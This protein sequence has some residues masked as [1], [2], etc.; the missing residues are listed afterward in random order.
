MTT[1]TPF[2]QLQAFLKEIFQ[3]DDHDLDFGIYRIIRLKRSFIE[4]FIDGHGQ[5]S[6]RAVVQE[7]LSQVRHDAGETARNWLSAFCAQFGERG[8]DLWRPLSDNPLDTRAR[9]KFQHFLDSPIIDEKDRDKALEHLE[10]LDESGKMTQADL[11]SRVYNHLLNFFELYYNNGDFGYNTRAS[12]AFKVPYEADYDG[13]DTMFHWKHKGSYYIKTGNGF[14]RIRSRINGAWLEF[15]I[16][17]RE[18]GLAS[19]SRNNVR[20]TQEKHYRL[21]QVR[22]VQDKDSEGNT[23]TVHQVLFSLAPKSTS[24]VKLYPA[25]WK[26]VFGSG[27]D[28]TPYLHKKPDKD[29]PFPGRPIFN[30]LSDSYD[31]VQSGGI[32]GVTQLRLK[33]ETY[34]TELAKRDEFKELGKNAQARAEA[35]GRDKTARALIEMDRR[36]NAFYAGNDA[37]FFIHKDLK[38]FLS[39]EKERYIKN[40]IFSDLNGLLNPDQDFAA[41]QVGRTFNQVADRIIAFLDAIENFQKKLFELKKKV[42]DTHYLISVGRIP[43][44]FYPRLFKCREQL[45][46][47]KDI[48][49]VD[50]RKPEDLTSHPTLVVDTGLY[51]QFDPD[52]QD[53]L[54][55]HPAFDHL[56]EQTDGLLI[57]SENWQAL[58]LMQEK[59]REKIKCIYIDPPYNTGGDGF[60]YKDAFRHSSWA[61]MMAD[62][63]E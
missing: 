3:F 44:E 43:D 25:V 26:Q 40:V 20:D 2:T 16:Q 14:P 35:L 59:F 61:T 49:L 5:D 7:S 38:G 62:R 10:K 47:W 33:E 28:L 34:F 11:E 57:N 52:L 41:V 17:D 56:D 37:D 8:Q 29:N 13:A 23:I 27:I 15:R 36:L 22:P 31:Q 6:L 48:F 30:D 53:D 54:L 42:V 19:T 60:L 18:E 51:S 12:Q 55:S 58:N 50:I 32:K 9:E 63:L 21:E 1:Q 46:E 24:K 39:N 45:S 4:S